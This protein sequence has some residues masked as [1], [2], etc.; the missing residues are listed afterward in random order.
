MPGENLE[1]KPLYRKEQQHHQQVLKEKSSFR[2]FNLEDEA[3]WKKMPMD[4]SG[5]F[6]HSAL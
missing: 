5:S 4:S 2:I 6:L 3:K 1:I